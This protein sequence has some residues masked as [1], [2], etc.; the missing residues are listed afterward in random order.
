MSLASR[1]LSALM[2]AVLV[3][4]PIASGA[5][6]LSPPA[7]TVATTGT[8]P[9]RGAAALEDAAAVLTLKERLGAK[10]KDDQ[11]VDNCKVPP[12]KR[13]AKPRPDSCVHP[14]AE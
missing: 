10:W 9:S 7:N 8:A 1:L 6:S 13:G 4:A 12:E 2:L 5:Q 3:V 14:P 11:R